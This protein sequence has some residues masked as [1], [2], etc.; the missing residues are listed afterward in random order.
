MKFLAWLED[1]IDKITPVVKVVTHSKKRFTQDSFQEIM[2]NI[3]VE[4]EL[5][6]R[7]NTDYKY[8]INFSGK[9]CR[10]I[11]IKNEKERDEA[12]FKR[13]N[14]LKSKFKCTLQHSGIVE[15]VAYE[16][17]LSTKTDQRMFQDILSSRL[18]S[19]LSVIEKNT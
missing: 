10:L 13:L 12:D 9:V 5:T 2:A 7:T 6:L 1:Q 3:L 18:Q 19:L 15:I 11:I 16:H 4:P 17:L 8:V 14:G